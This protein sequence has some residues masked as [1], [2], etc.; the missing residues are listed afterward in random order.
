MKRD[1]GTLFA[2]AAT[3]VAIAIY[4]PT[5]ATGLVGYDD[6][7]LVADN[8]IVQD[9]SW[10][11]LSTI[12]FDFD[13]PRRFVIAP[14][15]LPVRDLSV[16]LDFAIWGDNYGGHH[17]TNLALYVAAIWLWFGALVEL[18]ID[19]KVA[20]IAIFIWALHPSHAESVAWLA[21]RKG[22][23]GVMFAGATA[24]CYTRFRAGR[25]AGWLA[26]AMV[27]AVL[28]V[29]SKAH[30]AFAV[31]ALAALEVVLPARRVSW[32]RSLVGLGAI[33]VL[34]AAAFVPVLVMAWTSSVVGAEAAPAGRAEMIAGV[35]GFY[36]QHALMA[37]PNAVSYALSLAGP[38]VVDIALG[39]VGFVAIGVTLWR[40]PRLRP[41]AVLWLFGWLPVSHLVLPL[42]MVF[43]AD[44]YLLIPSL[45]FA[46]AVAVGIDRIAK[47]RL[48]YALLGV[49]AVAALLR[50]LDAR[51]NWRD[52]LTLWGRAVESNPADGSAWSSYAEAVS[53][54]A[55]AMA[56]VEQ[57]L[58]HSK[59]PRLLLR[60]AL[61][62]R[63]PEQFA[64]MQEA[65]Q[66]GEARAMS[67]LALLLLEQNRVDEALAWA[68][69]GAALGALHEPGQ[70]AL[71]RVALA[72]KQMP[73]ARAAFVRAFEL[74]P[75]CTNAYNL[76]LVEMERNALD[77]AGSLLDRCKNDPALGERVRAALAE[78][79]RR[80][81]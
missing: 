79:A 81:R 52:R 61:L 45:G 73:E 46:L 32:R 36:I 18:G 20:G 14:E 62:L 53:D 64:A 19:R 39:L 13:S 17:A 72:A 76:A 5:L 21:E 56:I 68:R 33:G 47:P 42:E 30:A 43:V 1:A 57:G 71:G 16:M 9:P 3:L 75:S 50:T 38:S 63:G 74:S 23:L 27:L 44:R 67:N 10:A 78:V 41:A 80:Q 31:G 2:I 70:R 49:I 22:L 69:R 60:R 34:A 7:W 51:T 35:H 8:Y 6:T 66:A 65:A 26:G 77:A 48:G 11:S 25:S 54:P 59:H 40:I 15:Y 12:F 58:T 37:K 29:W 55:L 4:V 28:A 24:L